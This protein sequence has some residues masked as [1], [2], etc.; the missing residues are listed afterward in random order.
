VR[1]GTSVEHSPPSWPAGLLGH[2]RHLQ[3]L[4]AKAPPL[5]RYGFDG[6]LQ[7]LGY[8]LVGPPI[9]LSIGFEQDASVEKL[10]SMS[11]AF[12]NEP[13]EMLPLDF[14]KDEDVLLWHEN[15]LGH[16]LLPG[17]IRTRTPLFN[18]RVTED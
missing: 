10:S 7:S 4:L 17:R 15:L 3:P 18:Q 8:P 6:N 12:A 9:C 2:K 16:H 1:F 5:S 11:L 13:F 14:G